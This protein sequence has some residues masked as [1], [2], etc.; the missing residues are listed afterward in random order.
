MIAKSCNI[1][2]M[3]NLMGFIQEISYFL[4]L[5]PKRELFLKDAEKLFDVDTTKDKLMDVG[6]NRWVA[7]IDVM[8]VFET[9]L[10]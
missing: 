4:N 7:R 10:L 5:L 3:L 2:K 1:Q 8:V 6:L 9:F